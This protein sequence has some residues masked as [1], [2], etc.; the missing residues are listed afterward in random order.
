MKKSIIFLSFLFVFL[1]IVGCTV[2]TSSTTETTLNTSISTEQTT[3]QTESSE[4]TSL[5]T[6]YFQ[7]IVNNL[8]I[9]SEVSDDFYLLAELDDI[10]VSWST[11]DST[12]IEISSSVVIENSSFVYPVTLKTRPTYVQGDQSVTVT[13]TFQYSEREIQ[14]VFEITILAVPARTYLDEDLALIQPNYVI[15]DSFV[16]PALTYAT[17]QNISISTEL[18]TYLTYSN[19]EFD[20][21]RPEEDITGTISF[22]VVYGDAAEEV[23]ININLLALPTGITYVENF[24]WVN[25]TVTAYAT[26]FSNTDDNG[27]VWNLFGRGNLAYFTFGNAADGSY[28]EVTVYGGIS[29]FSVDL[30]RA[31]TNTNVRSAELF[32]N[33]ISYGTFNVDTVSDAWQIFTVNNINISGNVVI[34]LV[35]TSPG[36]RGAFSINNFTW[37]TYTEEVID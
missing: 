23:I 36:D 22:E 32:I 9:N 15:E 31:F 33:D 4:T 17:Y 37:T 20:I 27:F 29:S 30:V 7:F 28:I 10:T 25:T 24:S 8:V 34:R 1:F 3:T 6:D 19:N 16:L 14:R 12:Y 2:K 21:I 5:T 13:G 26:A 35:S 11:T 18:S